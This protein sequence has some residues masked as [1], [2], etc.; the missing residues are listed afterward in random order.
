MADASQSNQ[1]AGKICVVTGSTRGIGRGTAVAL[2]E[3]GATVYV[4]GRTSGDSD[5]EARTIEGSAAAVEAAGGVGIPVQVDHGDD[6]F[7]IAAPG[8]ASKISGA[9]CHDAT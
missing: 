1:L 3:Q 6:T 4:T 8:P 7:T 9:A 5:A 2:G